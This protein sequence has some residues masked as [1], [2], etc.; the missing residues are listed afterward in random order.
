MFNVPSKL[1]FPR[2]LPKCCWN[3]EQQQQQQEST[4]T[5]HIC[6]SEYTSKMRM[7]GCYTAKTQCGK[8]AWVAL[9]TDSEGLW[10]IA[11]TLWGTDGRAGSPVC[12]EE[13]E[14]GTKSQWNRWGHVWLNTPTKTLRPDSSTTALRATCVQART[15]HCEHQ[16]NHWWH[17][18]WVSGQIQLCS[19]ATMVPKKKNMPSADVKYCSWIESMF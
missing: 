3:Y 13:K 1:V 2:N 12:Y 5:L 4:T 10:R 16:E 15:G 19:R 18:S 17:A 14:K 9:V 6:A 8:Y 11:A 7:L